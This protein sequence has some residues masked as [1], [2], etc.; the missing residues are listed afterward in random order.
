MSILAQNPNHPD[1]RAIALWNAVPAMLAA[2]PLP[3]STP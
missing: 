2:P 1:I 3:F